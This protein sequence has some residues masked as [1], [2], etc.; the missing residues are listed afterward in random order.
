[1]SKPQLAAEPSMEEILASI[2]KLITDDKPDPGPTQ[3]PFLSRTHAGSPGRSSIPGTNGFSALHEAKPAGPAPFNSLADALKVATTLSDQRRSLQQ[4][5]ISALDRNG[6]S[7]SHDGFDGLP[8]RGAS[9]LDNVHRLPETGGTPSAADASGPR[10]PSFPQWRSGPGSTELSAESRD[11]LSFD[12]GTV[13]PKHEPS[14]V[15]SPTGGFE[16]GKAGI[17]RAMGGLGQDAID[18]PAANGGPLGMN[19]RPGDVALATTVPFAD[20]P[21]VS[22]AAASAPIVVGAEPRIFSIP[23]RVPLTVRAETAANTNGARNDASPNGSAAN[24]APLDGTPQ[25]VVTSLT[26]NG[27][28]VAPFPR[29]LRE[30]LKSVE[31]AAVLQPLSRSAENIVELQPVAKE[32]SSDKT[33]TA[34]GEPISPP[35]QSKA[36]TGRTGEEPGVAKADAPTASGAASARADALLDAVVDLVQ[37]QPGALS[38]F[39]SG[40]SFISGVGAKKMLEEAASTATATASAT[41]TGAPPKLDRAAAELLRPM[42]RQWLADN[43]PRIVEEALRSELTEQTDGAGPGPGKA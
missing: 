31:Q 8:N 6:H 30:A 12:F 24:G 28:T 4:D 38:V 17:G 27:N 37:Q 34:R 36:E 2:R 39:A 22:G 33:A 32:L 29:P 41:P 43:M 26:V 42:L 10:L 40:S 14:T 1:M 23:A 9:R 16:A 18:G 15:K 7:E 3:D 13:V 5:V 11:L 19:G 35:A 21:G 20:A 25:D